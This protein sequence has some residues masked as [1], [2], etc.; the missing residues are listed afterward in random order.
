MR[1]YFTKRSRSF[2]YKRE[3]AL[4]T[5]FEVVCVKDAKLGCVCVVRHHFLRVFRRIVRMR[6]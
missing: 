3:R 6:E 2:D 1:K 5:R 4:D